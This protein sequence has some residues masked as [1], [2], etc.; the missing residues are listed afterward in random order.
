MSLQWQYNGSYRPRCRGI[1]IL[2][3]L[4]VSSLVYSNRDFDKSTESTPEDSKLNYETEINFTVKNF[5]LNQ[6]RLSYELSIAP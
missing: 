4:V 6:F 3:G 1:L 5:D 2:I